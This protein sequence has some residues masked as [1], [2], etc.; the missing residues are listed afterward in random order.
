MLE[1]LIECVRIGVAVELPHA[2]EVYPPIKKCRIESQEPAGFVGDPDGAW[3][4]NSGSV[5]E[6]L[7]H[8]GMV[9]R[10][11]AERIQVPSA[12]GSRSVPRTV[13]QS[14][15]ASG[16][17]SAGGQSTPPST[18]AARRTSW[19]PIASCPFTRRLQRFSRTALPSSSPW[20]PRA[21]RTWP[22]VEPYRHGD[23]QNDALHVRAPFELWI[24]L[25][26]DVLFILS[27]GY[28]CKLALFG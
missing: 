13:A 18:S 4:S 27:T 26:P 21:S 14:H 9:L 19:R 7:P 23:G 8:V 3:N 25:V 2:L 16:A 12:T 24:L 22:L 5:N 6:F 11:Q 1:K 28:S 17:C 15:W 10:E 20:P